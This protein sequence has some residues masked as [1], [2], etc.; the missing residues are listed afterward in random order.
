MFFPLRRTVRTT[1]KKKQT[2]KQKR[3]KKIQSYCDKSKKNFFTT[4][5]SNFAIWLASSFFDRNADNASR[6]NVW[7]PTLE[8]AWNGCFDLDISWLTRNMQTNKRQGALLIACCFSWAVKSTWYVD[9]WTEWKKKHIKP[10]YS[11]RRN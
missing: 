2:K 1:A 11:Y 5:G 10:L 9:L 3:N 7:M 4:I 8:S 6:V